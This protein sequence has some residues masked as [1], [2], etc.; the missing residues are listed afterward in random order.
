MPVPP[1]EL[2]A[3]FTIDG[4]DEARGAAREAARRPGSRATP[5]RASSLLAGARDAVLGALG[6]AVGGRARRRRARARRAARGA[7]GVARLS[8]TAARGPG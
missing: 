5:G 1:A 4:P 8:Y 7:A 2:T 3:H 6:D